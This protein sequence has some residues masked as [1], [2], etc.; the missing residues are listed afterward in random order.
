MSL[1]SVLENLP[2]FHNE[3]I[4]KSFIKGYSIVNR[5]QYKN[6]VCSVSGGS[7]SDIMLDII[8]RI[9][10]HKKVTYVWFDTGLEY[11]ATKDHLKY[12]ENRYGITIHRER[13]VKPIP[14]C[15]KK[16]GQPF[17]SKQVSEFISRLQRNN[18]SWED[19]SF[20]ALYNKYPKCKAAL[21]WWC[22]EW[23]IKSRFNINYNFGL[24]EFMMKNPPK[25]KISNQC[26]NFAKKKVAHNA[27]NLL[28]ADL[29]IYGVR[30]AEGGARATAY[31]NCYS[32][33]EDKID[34]YRPLFWFKEADKRDYESAFDIKHS[35]C[36][37]EWG[38]AR[39]GC[40]CCPY[41]Q[42]LGNE[43]LKT[44]KFEP[45]MYK[46]VYV[47]FGDSFEYTRQYKQFVK[48][49]KAKEK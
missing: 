4:L 2:E 43:L 20:E 29:N 22:N 42:E 44:S 7:D 17:L 1:Q 40:V 33:N 21:R 13:A 49:M 11:Q 14:T 36:Y 27:I 32:Y 6:I 16:Y 18:F 9:D 34:E 31:K 5:P 3:E 25:F 19:G 15:C 12:L 37:E 47:V 8:H 46:A 45:Q 38:F 39:T 28:N 24:K 23:G 48:E 41:G 26:C 30:K 35:A 10:E